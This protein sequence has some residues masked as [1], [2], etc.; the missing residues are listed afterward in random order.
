[1]SD[2]YRDRQFPS[3]SN[4]RRGYDN[5]PAQDESDPL[6]EL[7]RL[8]GQA[9][10]FSN[11]GRDHQQGASQRQA[12]E[13]TV[14]HGRYQGGYQNQDGYQDHGRYDDGGYDYALPQAEPAPY[15]EDLNPGPPSWMRHAAPVQPEPRYADDYDQPAQYDQASQHDHAPQYDQQAQSFSRNSNYKLGYE[16]T[17]YEQ[18]LQHKEPAFEQDYAYQADP[19]QAYPA[20]SRYDDL[21]YGEAPQ[22]QTEYYGYDQ[23]YQDQDFEQQYAEQPQPRRRGGMATAAVVLV[24]A[25][26]GTA[27]AYAYRS[28]TGSHHSG[29]P[30]IIK[31]DAGPNKIVP[32]GQNGNG[33]QIYD[34]VGDNNG[35]EKMVPREE[36]PVDVGNAPQAGPRV[37]FPPLTQ[38]AAPPAPSSVAP[39]TRPTGPGVANGTLN[40]DAPRPV[41]TLTIRPDQPETAAAAPATTATAVPQA[42]IPAQRAQQVGRAGAPLALSPQAPAAAPEPQSRVASLNPTTSTPSASGSYVQVSSQRSEADALSSFRVLQS[43][44]AGI[45]GSRQPVVRRADLGEK[46]VYYRAMIGPFASTEEATQFCVNLQSAG[47]KCLVQRN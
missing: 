1:M 9:D 42:Q 23:T 18:D 25:V 32:N 5:S 27:G 16:Q 13:P 39:N 20:D 30:P 28:L 11:F 4:P 8:I 34:R 26:V 15:A 29:E 35:G 43:K 10:P 46:G 47:G 7:A 19:R 12:A 24:L 31:A 41:R 22:Q 40:G 3:D 2:R 45:L 36:Q 21:L 6:A 33:K 17:V 38:N 37:V 44:Y 14:D